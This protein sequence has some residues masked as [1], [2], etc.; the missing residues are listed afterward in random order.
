MSTTRSSEPFDHDTSWDLIPWWVNE[1]LA[2]EE[3]EGVT[4]HVN[5]CQEC[6]TE[7]REQRRLAEALSRETDTFTDL[8]AGWNRLARAL[9]RES[10][11]APN[12]RASLRRLLIAAVIAQVILF[13]G[14]IGY[15]GW[16]QSPS[17]AEPFRTLSTPATLAAG[18]ARLRVVPAPETTISKLQASLLAVD[19]RI[20][21]GPSPAGVFTISVPQAQQNEA[22]GALR[23]KP[24]I[25]LAE[26]LPT[27]GP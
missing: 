19:G 16:L 5:H 15:V 9:D 1:S 10:K 27:E 12:E 23:S 14:M 3:A 6:Q 26:P 20:V 17:N 7:V 22:L 2:A 25:L 4:Q 13:G 21:D 24:F 8:E 11:G 18:G